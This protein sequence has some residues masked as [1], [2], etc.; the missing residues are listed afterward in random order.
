MSVS[1]RSAYGIQ[2]GT[3]RAT[4]YIASDQWR[5]NEFE[6]G[7]GGHRSGAERWK[8]FLVLSL[9]FLALKAQLV[10]SVSAFVM[11]STV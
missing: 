7:G 1:F 4:L 11:V 2:N 10:V 9:H 6:N 5:R 8:K 3:A